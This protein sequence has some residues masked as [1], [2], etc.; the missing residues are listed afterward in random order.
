MYLDSWQ[1]SFVTDIKSSEVN[2]LTVDFCYDVKEFSNFPI[3]QS[4]IPM[5]IAPNIYRT[6]KYSSLS[7]WMPFFSKAK[8]MKI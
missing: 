6:Y 7:D 1:N 4:Q 5:L 2:E 3:Y 8:P